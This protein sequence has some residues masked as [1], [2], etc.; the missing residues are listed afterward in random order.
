MSGRDLFDF[1][2]ASCHGRDAKGHG[3]VASKLRDTP[4]DLTVI[5]KVNGGTFPRAAVQAFVTGDEPRPVSTHG[6]KDMPVWGPVFRGLDAND[7]LNKI[8]IDNIVTYI[9]TL[10]V[11]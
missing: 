5:A 3:P 11:K 2:C 7:K 10:Q 6:T 8:R 1:Y 4:T 9:G